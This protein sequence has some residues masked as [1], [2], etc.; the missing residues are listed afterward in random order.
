M[1]FW[2]FAIPHDV[3]GLW[4]LCRSRGI[5]AMHFTRGD[6]SWSNNPPMAAKQINLI[7]EIET[8]DR[9]IAWLRQNRVCGIGT[10]TSPFFEDW[11]QTNGMEGSFGQR[12]ALEWDITCSIQFAE[13][14]HKK[15]SSNDIHLVK[16]GIFAHDTIYEVDRATYERALRLYK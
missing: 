6:N 8:G 13:D 3:E 16:G 11:S 4:E 14:Y 5:L 2:I 7:R 1:R 15:M 10:V 9:V 12:I